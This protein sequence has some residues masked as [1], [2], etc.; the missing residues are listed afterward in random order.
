MIRTLVVA[1]SGVAM[2]AIT[3][4]LSQLPQVAIVAYASGRAPLAAVVEAVSPDVVMVDQMRHPGRALDRIAETRDLPT[5]VI[6]LA[7]RADG[8]WV[9]AALHAGATAVVPRDLEPRVLVSV[10]RD[11]LDPRRLAPLP[12]HLSLGGAA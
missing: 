12:R 7:E 2:R 9:G 8:P 3:A 11:V 5:A 4:S 1:D 6:G 10:I